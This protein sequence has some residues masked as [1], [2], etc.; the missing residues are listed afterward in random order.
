[1]SITITNISNT[2][3]PLFGVDDYQLRINNKVIC[4]FKHKREV[5]GL[6]QC[7]RDAADAVDNKDSTK[8]EDILKLINDK[9]KIK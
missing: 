9:N 1:M 8:L 4:K 2:D 5:N 7:L 3:S 6:A